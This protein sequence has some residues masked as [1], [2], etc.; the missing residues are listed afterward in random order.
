MNAAWLGLIL[1]LPLDASALSTDR[2][3]PIEVE[4]DQAELDNAAGVSTYTGNVVVTQGSMR[5]EADRLVVRTASGRFDSMQATG[6]PAHFR[7]RP[8]GQDVD[9]EGGGRTIDYLSAKSLV[10]LTGDAWVNQ[11]K[12]KL[13]GARIEYNVIEDRVVAKRT[14]EGTDRVR[15]ILQPKSRDAGSTN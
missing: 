7:Q 15:M 13:R 5:L 8:D 12:D 3:E 6:Q 11:G 1:L 14:P 9:V 2:N 10:V 4:A